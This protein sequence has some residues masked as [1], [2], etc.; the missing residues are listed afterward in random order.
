MRGFVEQVI[1]QNRHGRHS[2]YHRYRTRKYAGI[3]PSASFYDCRGSVLC[4]GFLFHQDGSDWLESHPE[5]DVLSVA[6]SALYASAIV[7]ACSD[8]SIF[9]MK[10]SFCSLPRW[11]TPAN[12][13]PYSNPFTALMPNMAP[14]NAAWSLLKAGS[15]NPMGQ[16]RITPV[17]IPPIVSPLL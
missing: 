15:P 2:F 17:M 14:P 11:L 9:A 5:I 10:T 13:R 6:D 16:W 7:G 8:G 12:P 4:Y 1:I 3:V